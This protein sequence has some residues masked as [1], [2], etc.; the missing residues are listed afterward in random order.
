MKQA[1]LLKTFGL[2]RTNLE[3]KFWDIW[4]VSCQSIC[5]HFGTLNPLS[6]Y[7]INQPL[8]MSTKI[9]LYI[10]I[11][12]IYLGLGFEFEF[13]PQRIRDFAFVCP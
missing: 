13:W 8:H 5:V 10:H 12:N 4:D 9:S 2:G 11:P 6:M 1:E 7:S 3:D